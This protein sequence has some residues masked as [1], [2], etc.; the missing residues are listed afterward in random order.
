M[1]VLT[2][3]AMP[4]T[5][6]ADRASSDSAR[7]CEA[8]PPFR[9]QQQGSHAPLCVCC[10]PDGS[11][12]HHCPPVLACRLQYVYIYIYIYIYMYVYMGFFT[13]LYNFCACSKQFRARNAVYAPVV[14]MFGVVKWLSCPSHQT[15]TS[16]P[17]LYILCKT[18]TLFWTQTTATTHS[19]F[20]KTYFDAI[21]CQSESHCCKYCCSISYMCRV[22]YYVCVDLLYT[23][24]I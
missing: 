20:G 3:H 9:A 7:P 4:H 13:L 19:T 21:F 8:V 16:T 2:R 24:L 14:L 5:C 22:C 11:L 10:C 1:Q 23:S 18:Q 12:W 15:Q 6:C 17:W